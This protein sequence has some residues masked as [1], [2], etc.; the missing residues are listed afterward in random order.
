MLRSAV[1]HGAIDLASEA[2]LRLGDV[3]VDPARLTV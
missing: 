2:E 1:F 3:H